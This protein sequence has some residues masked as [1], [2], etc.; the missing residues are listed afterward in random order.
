[1]VDG[2]YSEVQPLILEGADTV[3]WLDYS[4]GTK[5][6]RLFRRTLRRALTQERLWGTNT[7]TF[8]KAFLSRDAIFVWFFKTHWR[9]RRRY[10]ARFGALPPHVTLLRLFEPDE[11]EAFLKSQ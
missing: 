5:L 8:R 10:E 11:A 9:Q 6:W 7:E 1:V 2:N 4:V 3:I